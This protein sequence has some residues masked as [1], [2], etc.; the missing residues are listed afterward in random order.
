MGWDVDHGNARQVESL[1]MAYRYVIL[2][3]NLEDVAGIGVLERF[4]NK[5]NRRKEFQPQG[6][7]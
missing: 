3:L 7:K 2:E 4:Q 6:S 5:W 1:P